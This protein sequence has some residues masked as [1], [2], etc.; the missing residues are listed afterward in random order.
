MY[1]VHPHTHLRKIYAD[2]VNI[3]GYS[4]QGKTNEQVRV[5]TELARLAEIDFRDEGVSVTRSLSVLRFQTHAW[6]SQTSHYF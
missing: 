3:E 2:C 4:V 6:Y 1:I 5:E